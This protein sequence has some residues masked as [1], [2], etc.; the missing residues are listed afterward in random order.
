M[1]DSIWARPGSVAGASGDAGTQYRRGVAAYAAACGLAGVS[2]PELEIPPAHARV[3]SVSLET[4][5]AVDDI[6]IDF[7]SGWRA[8]VQA[9]RSLRIGTPL[10]EAVGQWVHAAKAGLDPAKDRLVIV[11]GT[12]SGPMKTLQQVLNRGRTDH[13]GAPT[14]SEANVLAT[15]RKLLDHLSKG[16]QDLVLKCAVI[17]ELKVEEP[18]EP[19]SLQA[20]GHLRHVVSDC[21][22]DTSRQAWSTLMDVSGRAARL[23][24]GYELAGWLA[25]LHGEGIA[26]TREGSG[27]A[28]VLEI[29]RQALEQYEARVVRDGSEIDLRALGAELPPLRLDDADARVKVVDPDDNQRNE[30]DLIWAFLRRGR[31]VLTGL[32][33]GGKSTALR[34]LAAQLCSDPT[35]PLPVR[36]SLRDIDQFDSSM[37][38]RDRL[39]A[40]AVRNERKDDRE[41]LT[42]EINDRLDNAGDVALLLDS[43]DETYDRRR[44]VI[45]EISALVADISPGVSIL[46]ATRDV[47]YGQAATLG[48]SSLRLHSP[49]DAERTVTAILEVAA[50]KTEPTAGRSRW[51]SERE[52]WV[53]SALAQDTLLA[54]TPLI[55]V[56]LTILAVRRATELLPLRRARILEAIVQDFVA[57]HE[58]QRGNGQT[59]GRLEQRE[60]VTASMHAFTS[61]A[62]EIQSSE[63]KASAKSVVEAIAAD[64]REPW[65]L[66]PAQAR[67]AGQDAVRLFDESGIFVMSGGR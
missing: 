7:E 59:L 18:S 67:T 55:P 4:D 42:A 11:A 26:I 21:S 52:A 20:I 57:E 63:G 56:L 16:E 37:G 24:G 50:P 36:V 27:P 22:H 40:V 53:R 28:A 62:A 1:G 46:L 38:F 6:R 34:Q 41:V 23:R 49:S 17:W 31:M 29:R 12:L 58:L 3:T 39:I 61:A 64:L 15:V 66:A 14:K 32:P 45:S 47:A 9:K 19:G 44:T 13:P 43:L 60:S 5:N 51:I 35:L 30:R 48:W 8:L 54:E 33:G 65:G 10:N 25:A 2:L